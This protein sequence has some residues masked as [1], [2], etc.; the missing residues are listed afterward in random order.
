MVLMRFTCNIQFTSM[1][2]TGC[3]FIAPSLSPAQSFEKWGGVG[4]RHFSPWCGQWVFKVNV[5]IDFQR[6]I[7]FLHRFA[8]HPLDPSDSYIVPQILE[9]YASP[10]HYPLYPLLRLLFPFCPLSRAQ[11]VHPRCSSP[12]EMLHAGLCHPEDKR[13]PPWSPVP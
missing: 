12:C 11:S 3:L 6:S 8:P 4:S 7:P 9:Q 1:Q 2:K 5:Y 13:K 10:L